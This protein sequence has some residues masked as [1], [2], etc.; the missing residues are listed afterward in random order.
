M[1]KL[2][3]KDIKEILE[4]TEHYEYS[5]SFPKEVVEKVAKRMN[6]AHCRSE[7]E[8]ANKLEELGISFVEIPEGYLVSFS[9]PVDIKLSR[10]GINEIYGDVREKIY[11]D[12]MIKFNRKET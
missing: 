4:Q 8:V 7:I 1:R 9:K 5:K 6:E 12:K 11:E 10:F 3:E 2:E